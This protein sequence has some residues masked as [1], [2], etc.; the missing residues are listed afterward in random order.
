MAQHMKRIAAP[1]SWPLLRKAETFVSVPEGSHAFEH[2]ISVNLAFTELLKIAKTRKEV[3]YIIFDKEV[4]VN[5]K[6]IN[7]EKTQ[8]GLFDVL[9][10]PESKQNFTMVLN[11]RGKLEVKEISEADANVKVTKIIGKKY[12]AGKKIQL[13]LFE[14]RN[15]LVDKDTYQVGDAL[16]VSIPDYKIKEQ[17]KL[18]KGV[19]VFLLTGQHASKIAKIESITE[20][21]IVCKTDDTELVVN[22]ENI[23]VLG[24]G[25]LLL[26]I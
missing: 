6:K 11:S 26:N 2:A 8:F 13:N 14:G 5:G 3:R 7:T 9:S 16:V 21:K 20:G 24:K 1:R 4:R 22:K 15:I 23:F 12:L 25:K 18:E 10:L 19:S 17:V